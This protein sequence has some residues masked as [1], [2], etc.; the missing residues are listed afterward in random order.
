MRR[1]RWVLVCGLLLS[2]VAR[3]ADDRPDRQ[4]DP[5]LQTQINRAIQR[6]VAYLRKTQGSQGRW[7][8]PRGGGTGGLT[9]L[10]LYALAASRVAAD[11]PAIVKGLAWTK[12]HRQDFQEGGAY[13]TYSASLLVL[14][15]TRIDPKA[16]KERI[17]IL[18]ERIWRSQLPSDMWT[19]NLRAQRRTNSRKKDK[20]RK[21]GN[22][23]GGGDNSNSQFAVL[24]LWAAYALADAE[25]PPATWQRIHDFYRRTQTSTG[26]WSYTPGRGGGRGRPTM[27]AAGLVSYVYASAALAGGVRALP[28]ARRTRVAQAGVKALFAGHFNFDDN[29][30]VYSLER[31]GTVMG[32]PEKD[33]YF[34]GAR[35][36]IKRQK[37]DGRWQGQMRHGDADRTY[38]TSLALLFLSRATRYFVGPTTRRA[39]GFPDVTQPKNLANAFDH[40]HH[41]KPAR[42]R[43][44]I[45]EFGKAGP[46]AVGFF[47]RKLRHKQAPVRETA[48]ELLKEL[49]DRPLLFEPRWPARD[50]A[51]MLQTI[52]GFWRQ[53]RKRLHWDAQRRRF[54]VR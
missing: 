50:R 23:L 35:T 52:D 45:H 33:W 5:K 46:A 42:R 27:T 34:D 2:P 16:H 31:V 44:V 39:A 19:Y 3:G 43:E 40:Y 20:S 6:G 54:V 14:A 37:K 26:G 9:A 21:G 24:A 7:H 38:E 1:V 11:D 36:L 15:L 48:A 28:Q 41:Y 4:A 51:H 30:F 18:A 53:N 32:V 25:V 47:I 17:D 49:V 10:A 22:R 8:Y 13:G 12:K 29:Y